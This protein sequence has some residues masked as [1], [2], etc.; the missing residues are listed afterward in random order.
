MAPCLFLSELTFALF[1]TTEL[2]LLVW[3]L[4][5]S[6]LITYSYLFSPNYNQN[7]T[8]IKS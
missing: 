3:T 2:V 8:K 7:Q 5:T 4:Y 1:M 6:F